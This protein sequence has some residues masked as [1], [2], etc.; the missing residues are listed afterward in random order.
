MTFIRTAGR[1]GALLI[2][3]ALLLVACGG[4]TASGVPASGGTSGSTAAAS[5][6]AEATPTTDT[7]ASPEAS[8]PF[9]IPSF[10]IG[11]LTKGLDKVDS[12]RVAITV[13]GVEQ[14]KGV[15]VTKPVLSRDIT[16]SG[17]TRIV[18]IGS[19]AWVADGSGVLKPVPSQLASSMFAA[20]DP[21]LLVGAFSG[22]EWAQS[23][24]DKGTE[25]KN[26]VNA[27][28]LVIDSSTLAAGVTGLPAGASINL[29]I[30][31][32]GYLVAWES[33]G[34]GA[35]DMSIQVTGVDDPANK[36]ERPG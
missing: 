24:A 15:V 14:Y 33:T 4:G 27:H 25:K 19:E 5:T 10:D 28:H 30:A 1:A 3:I 35:G 11:A 20:F 36:V 9:A 2:S 7:G 13:G 8:F 29:W 34:T 6:A 17:G 23:S 31:D 12:Y 32:A 18:V 21:T 26:G 22:P 16:I